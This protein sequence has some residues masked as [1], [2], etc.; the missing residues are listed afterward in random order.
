ME[1][2]TFIMIFNILQEEKKM[3][4][5]VKVKGSRSIERM[6]VFLLSAVFLLVGLQVL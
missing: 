5:F 1:L 2:D 6:R 3:Y 4:C